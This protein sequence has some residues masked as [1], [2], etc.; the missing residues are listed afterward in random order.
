MLKA[1]RAHTATH[2]TSAKIDKRRAQDDWAE[3]V[4]CLEMVWTSNGQMR[5]ICAAHGKVLCTLTDT[6]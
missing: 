5:F 4:V 3:L 1:A 6:F 2:T